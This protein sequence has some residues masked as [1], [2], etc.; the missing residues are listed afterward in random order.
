MV[1]ALSWAQVNAHEGD[2]GGKRVERSLA[3][4][5]QVTITPRVC[6]TGVPIPAAV[7][8]ALLTFHEDGTL[9]AWTQNAT[10]S[11]TRSPN[12]GLWERD[13]SWNRYSFRFVHLRYGL[14]DGKYLG[15]QVATA[16]AT[17]A[18]SGNEFTS[19]GSIQGLLPNGDEEYVGCSTS[20]GVRLELND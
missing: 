6:A 2:H 4:V 7:S 12:H 15:K 19:E 1:L 9:S 13:R 18:R 5:W 10:I 16:V 14:V 11:T 17:L 3:G 20:V 8:Q